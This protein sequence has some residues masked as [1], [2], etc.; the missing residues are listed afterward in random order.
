MLDMTC[1]D[2]LDAGK[3]QDEVYYVYIPLLWLYSPLY[4]YDFI[5]CILEIVSPH[6]RLYVWPAFLSILSMLTTLGCSPRAAWS[7]VW[8]G[9]SSRSRLW[10][11]EPTC[12]CVYISAVYFIYMTDHMLL[13]DM[14]YSILFSTIYVL[15]MYHLLPHCVVSYVYIMLFILFMYILI[16]IY[17]PCDVR[18]IVIKR[19]SS[20]LWGT[21]CYIWYQSCWFNTPGLLLAY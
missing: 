16:I 6:T 3:E 20:V 14:Y 1:A 12:R 11:M 13:W 17:Y 5:Y 21:G 18:L 15:T 19:R 8:T 10:S 9:Y 2:S 7:Q 4:I